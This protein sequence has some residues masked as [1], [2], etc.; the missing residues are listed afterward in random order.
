M[1]TAIGQRF[2]SGDHCVERGQYEFDGYLDGSSALLPALEE[3]EVVLRSGQLF[4]LVR[5]QSRACFWTIGS[6]GETYD[7]AAVCV[8]TVDW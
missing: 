2:K 3:M 7:D 1:T 5:S 4:P 8:S 6:A